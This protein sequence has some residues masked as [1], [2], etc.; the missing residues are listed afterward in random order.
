MKLTPY[1]ICVL[2]S[3]CGNLPTNNN[4][5]TPKS[6]KKNSSC[7]LF[8]T[9]NI[10]NTAIDTL[11]IHPLSSVYI[12]SID[13][14]S[15]GRPLPIKA[16]FGTTWRGS[17]L[18]IPYDKVPANQPMVPITFKW[19]DESDL[20]DTS[21]CDTKGNSN[22]GC[23]PIPTN[24][25][26]EGGTDNH[27]I[28]LQ[29]ESCKL[30]EVFDTQG[31]PG[32]WS[33]ASGA[34]WDLSKNEVRPIGVTSADAA[35]LPILPGLIRYE[36]IYVDKVINHVIRVTLEQIQSAYLRPPASHSDGRSGQDRS[37]PPMGLQLRLKANYDISGFDPNIQVILVALKKYG[38]IV[39]DTGGQMYI[40]GVHDDRWNKRLLR[41]LRQVK[42]TD[43]EA[44]DTGAQLVDYP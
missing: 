15:P 3:A 13:A 16:D 12:S 30:Y 32:N 38:L 44:V 17:D 23:Y 4:D 28:L 7:M 14:Y 8:P 26:I 24:P 35:G 19:A 21:S 22:T 9:N 29:K 20:G 1:I 31:S 33:G 37:F 18:G 6:T 11:P 34:I 39:A 2:L 43:F 25:S 5:T 40:S 10:W 41:Q 36:E 42:I 27:I